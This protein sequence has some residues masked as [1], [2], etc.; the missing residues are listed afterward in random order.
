MSSEYAFIVVSLV[1]NG[2]EI[3]YEPGDG[4]VIHPEAPSLDVESFLACVGYS[5]FADDPISIAHTLHGAFCHIS[6]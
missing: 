6:V 2:P 5:N 3:M 4:A 1:L